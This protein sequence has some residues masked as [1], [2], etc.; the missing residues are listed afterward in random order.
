MRKYLG[1]DFFNL[2]MKD[3]LVFLPNIVERRPETRGET[4]TVGNYY[5]TALRMD[6]RSVKRKNIKRLFKAIKILNDQDFKLLILGDGNYLPKVKKWAER[7]GIVENLIFKGKVL[8]SEMDKYY[9]NSKA[10]LMPSLSESFGMVYAE[11]L[12]NGAPIMY[13]KET[14]GFDGIF[15]NVGVGI[16]PLSVESIADGI[17]D[18]EINH[19]AYRRHIKELQKQG[20]FDIFTSEHVRNRYEEIINSL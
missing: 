6:R 7:F 14:M 16:N 18:L 19:P 9:S 17:R 15:E 5:S 12:E 10:F 2:H 3:K 20:E 4:L 13:S 1:E 8:N 11:S